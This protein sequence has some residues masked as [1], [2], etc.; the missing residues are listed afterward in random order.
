M[1][2]APRLG[3]KCQRLLTGSSDYEP[4]WIC[5]FI[6]QIGEQGAAMLLADEDP[7]S[8]PGAVTEQAVFRGNIRGCGTDGESVA[9]S[10][11]LAN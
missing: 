4:R 8:E 5:L 1:K 11:E 2:D 6:E 7:P 3:M 10:A 9:S